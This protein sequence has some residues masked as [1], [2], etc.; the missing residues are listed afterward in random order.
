[1]KMSVGTFWKPAII[2]LAGCVSPAARAST[3]VGTWHMGGSSAKVCVI[4]ANMD[5]RLMAKNESGSVSKLS[6]ESS[7][8]C[9]AMDWNGVRGTMEH[10]RILWSNGTW[11]SRAVA[12]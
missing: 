9:T 7:T 5:G 11:W 10:E 3:F 8:Q 1:M 12:P 2:L 6:C 4:S